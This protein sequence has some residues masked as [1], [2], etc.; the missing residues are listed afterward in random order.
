MTARARC[1]RRPAPGPSRRWRCPGRGR[2]NS[3]DNSSG[4]RA[5]RFRRVPKL[6]RFWFG[7]LGGDEV[8]LAVTGCRHGRS[9]LPRRA[10]RGA[11]GG[12]A[13]HGAGVRRGRSVEAAPDVA[14][15]LAACADAPHRGDPPRSV[16]RRVRREVAP[17]PRHCSTPT[18]SG[19]AHDSRAASRTRPAGHGRAA[20]RR[21]VEGRGRRAAERREEFAGQRTGRVSARGGVGGR[22]H[23]ARRG[24]GAGRVRRLAGRAGR[25]R[26][27]PRDA[28]AWRP[29]G[30]SGRRRPSRDAR[31]VLWV[32]DAADPEGTWP[33]PGECPMSR[34]DP[35]HQQDRS[36]PLVGAGRIQPQALGSGRLR[37]R[38]EPA[39][40]N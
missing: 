39:S 32:M 17:H 23:D 33:K 29:K 14:R 36:V 9:P 10:A 30:S 26:R 5:S 6:H 16:P 21:A 31:L 2:G 4:P 18:P 3:R 40:P 13:V 22:G 11:V 27:A 12:R 20:P 38:W 19:T 25:H 24:H 7:T 1:S 35:R 15:L 28:R 37:D 34:C 8:I